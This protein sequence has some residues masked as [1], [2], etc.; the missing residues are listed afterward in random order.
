MSILAK[1]AK[2]KML[3]LFDNEICTIIYKLRFILM[4]HVRPN[5]WWQRRLGNQLTGEGHVGESE[6]CRKNNESN[7]LRFHEI[8]ILYFYL[9]FESNTY[10]SHLSY[11]LNIYHIYN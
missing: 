4:K 10:M 8:L 2:Q 9:K 5:E 6:K 3:N 11:V 1:Y 7:I